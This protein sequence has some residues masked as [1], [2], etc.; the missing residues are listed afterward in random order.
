MPVSSVSFTVLLIRVTEGLRAF[1]E[2]GSCPRRWRGDR[3]S[4]GP[5]CPLSLLVKTTL[6]LAWNTEGWRE[7][8]TCRPGL[9]SGEFSCEEV[10]GP[11]WPSEQVSFR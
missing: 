6:G 4:L 5:D 1:T 11:F 10:E 9:S 2:K 7:G 8:G 3:L